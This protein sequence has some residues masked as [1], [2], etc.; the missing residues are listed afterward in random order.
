MTDAPGQFLHTAGTVDFLVRNGRMPPV[1]VVGVTNTD[2]TRDLTPTTRGFRGADGRVE[3]RPAA[4][5]GDRFLDFFEK[6]LIPLVESRYR[7]QP[8]RVFAGH[9][10][11]GLF[12][13]N[14]FATRPELFHAVIAVAPSLLWDDELP[15]RRT[16]D[17]LAARK[18]QALA[19]TLVVTMGDEG[20]ET[21]AALSRVRAALKGNG[22]KGLEWAVEK[23]PGEDHG[24]VVLPSHFAALQKVFA[25]WQLPVEAGT[26]VPAA[27]VEGVRRHYA[28]LSARV[29]YTVVPPEAQVNRAGYA[30]VAAG[31]RKDAIELLAMNVANY[32][33]SA[34]TYD[35]LGE[36]LE[37]DGQLA[38]AKE[39]YEKAVQLGRRNNDPALRAFEQHLEAIAKKP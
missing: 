36:A 37:A 22:V 8:Y 3:D 25:G 12:A 10:F 11:G 27:G 6:E 23:F 38:K 30:L 5:G 29:G 4:G 9:S 33:E 28:A 34:N 19:R 1:M 18:G 26:G 15:L 21:D 13:M 20:D 17:L 35:S 24:S 31:R 16:K 7:T 14:A 39:N 32:P 2:R